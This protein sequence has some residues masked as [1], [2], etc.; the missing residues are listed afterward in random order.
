[1]S[2]N[3]LV[4][5]TGERGR[6]AALK[7]AIHVAREKAE[8]TS[9]RQLALKAGVHY[10]TLMNWFAGRTL[11]RPAEL[12]KIADV[13]GV[14]LVDLMDVYEG[15]DPEPPDLIEVI[16]QLVDEL[17]VAVV[18]MR[19]GRVAQEEQTAAILRAIGS[20]VRSGPGPRETP[21]RTEREA[22]AGSGRG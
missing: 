21:H 15:R 2:V 1:M 12:K 19:M 20:A 7:L 16:G 8:I 14:R 18:E 17:R 5:V 10:D 3:T 13:L 4:P 22:P 6:G 9:D 11:P